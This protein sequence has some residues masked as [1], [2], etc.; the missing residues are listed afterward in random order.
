MGRNNKQG[1]LMNI[2]VGVIGAALGGWVL[3]PT[4][5]A[6]TRVAENGRF[7]VSAGRLI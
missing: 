2:I 6:A 5:T 7:R 1:C 4:G 3:S